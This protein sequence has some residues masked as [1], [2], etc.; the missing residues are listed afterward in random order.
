MAAGLGLVGLGA[1]NEAQAQ[2]G[3]LPQW[4]PGDFWDPGW[5]P[6]SDWNRCHDDP[7]QV[8][9]PPQPLHGRGGQGGTGTIPADLIT[10]AHL[11]GRGGLPELVGRAD[12]VARVGLPEL[13]GRADPVARAELPVLVGRADLADQAELGRPAEADPPA[14][15][16]AAAASAAAA[17]AAAAEVAEAAEV[18]AADSSLSRPSLRRRRGARVIEGLLCRPDGNWATSRALYGHSGH[19]LASGVACS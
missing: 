12:P 2:P 19:C 6:N 7:V 10:P 1:A 9:P 4:C 8:V 11:V 3:P 16:S 14:A 15:A 17:S 5:G 13:V 18:A